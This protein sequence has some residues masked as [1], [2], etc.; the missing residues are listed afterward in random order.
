MK[1][2]VSYGQTKSLPGFNNVRANAE[3]EV[4]VNDITKIDDAYQHAWKIV[5]DQVNKNLE[6]GLPQE[7]IPF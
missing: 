1:L 2:K 5:R 6:P 3:F 4:E 7:E